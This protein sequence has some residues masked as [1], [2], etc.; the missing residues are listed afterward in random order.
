MPSAARFI[1]KDSPEI[2]KSLVDESRLQ[3]RSYSPEYAQ[4][5]G[6]VKAAEIALGLQFALLAIT[7]DNPDTLK[8]VAKANPWQ[9]VAMEM[10]TGSPTAAHQPLSHILKDKYSLET[11]HH[12]NVRGLSPGGRVLDTQGY[13]AHNDSLVVLAF[14]CTTSGLD[15][16]TNLST[17]TSA[18]EIEE[19][20]AKGHS[21]YFSACC[22][23]AV[24]DASGAAK[25][26]VHTGFYNNLIATIPLIQMYI[27]PLLAPG[28]P[29]R[30]LYV[31]G[32][33]LGAG[34]AT[35]AACYFLLERERYPWENNQHKLRVVTA[36][37]PRAATAQMQEMIDWRVKEVN[38]DHRNPLG[39]NKVIFARVVRDKDVVPTLPPELL[40]FRHIP[41]TMIFLTKEDSQGKSRI[42]INPN[43][44]NVVSKRKMKKLVEEDPRL[45]S[46]GID[47]EVG[48]WTNAPSVDGSDPGADGDD[49]S[50]DDIT[51]AKE[52]SPGV[53]GDK[54]P[55]T[56]SI[57]SQFR[58]IPRN[59][60]DHMPQFYLNPVHAQ[61][62]QEQTPQ[63]YLDPALAHLLQQSGSATLENQ[64]KQQVEEKVAESP[65][66]TR[67]GFGRAFR[68]RHQKD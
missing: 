39:K 28:Q 25:P 55:A 19:D 67:K 33:S 38:S 48:S 51:D 65:T 37:G 53:D 35:L 44:K 4:Q 27:D 21:G 59:V 52:A 50:I 47:P 20:T 24:C 11:D 31:V 15:W 30:T 32:H 34:I 61:L 49:D 29:P 13:I 42:L 66:K 54:I 60:R 5:P 1:L 22:G 17:T 14:R 7:D 68:F 16:L 46:S 23:F 10:L 3:G 57:D 26:R 12:I 8:N 45:I 64:Q 2:L 36:G 9:Q 58:M 62:L 63:I 18:W 56:S 40:G 6:G 43:P 41:E